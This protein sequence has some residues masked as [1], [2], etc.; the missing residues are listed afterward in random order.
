MEAP[1]ELRGE[2]HGQR[3]PR[4]EEPLALTTWMARLN[5]QSAL[6]WADS[7]PDSPAT[8]QILAGLARHYQERSFLD[9]ADELGAKDQGTCN[10]TVV[11]AGVKGGSPASQDFRC[12]NHLL[13]NFLG[14]VGRRA[15][16]MRA[17]PQ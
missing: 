7:N 3:H 11:G 8:D 14:K 1:L 2:R 9:K 13:P 12:P 17:D 4:P 6:D 15:M 16:L 10:P 5:P